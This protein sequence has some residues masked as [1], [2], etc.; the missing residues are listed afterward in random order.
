MRAHATARPFSNK[1]RSNAIQKE[2]AAEFDFL[3]DGDVVLQ[4]DAQGRAPLA[5]EERGTGR[6]WA[7]NSQ[8][9]QISP[10]G[11]LRAQYVSACTGDPLNY[12][13]ITHECRVDATSA[14][15]DVLTTRMKGKLLPDTDVR[16]FFKPDLGTLRTKAD[17]FYGSE[18]VRWNREANV[19]EPLYDLFALAKPGDE[20]QTKCIVRDDLG[21]TTEAVSK[22]VKR[23]Q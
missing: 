14:R 2:L 15:G 6:R 12:N 13:Q 10:L 22:L 18:I 3:P 9:Q 17:T 8:L 16:D 7:A 1:K 19:V 21:D 20:L 11:Q 4:A 5:C 23:T